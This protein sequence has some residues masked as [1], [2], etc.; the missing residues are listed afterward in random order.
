MIL[1]DAMRRQGLRNSTI[2]AAAADDPFGVVRRF[3][4]RLDGEST[5]K[6][7]GQEN[8]LFEQLSADA[9]PPQPFEFGE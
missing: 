7:S 8:T 9:P 5:I 6:L 1:L 2:E 4:A 3:G